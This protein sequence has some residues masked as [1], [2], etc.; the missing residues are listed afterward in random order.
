[1]SAPYRQVFRRAPGIWSLLLSYVV[2]SVVYSLGIQLYGPFL[3]SLVECEVPPVPGARFSGSAYCGDT[4]R[5]LAVAQ[6]QEGSLVS[7]KLAVHAV[8]G[9]FLG[10]FADR[11]GRRPVLLA[12]L[13]GY[14]VAF[15]LLFVVAAKR[16]L[17][18]YSLL[19]LVFFIEG[20]TNA[21]D[22]VYMSMI[23]DITSTADRATAFAAYFACSAGGQVAAQLLSVGILR[24]CLETYLAVWLALSVV[25]AADVL[26]AWFSVVETLS[27]PRHDSFHDGPCSSWGLHAAESAVPR[28]RDHR[29]NPSVPLAL[30]VLWDPFQ[31]VLSAQFLR[32]WLLSVLLT[33]LAAGLSSILAAF[34]IGVYG[35]RPGDLQ[36]YTWFSQLL[37]MGSLSCISPYA[38]RVGS[39]AAIVLVQVLLT[40]AA[41]F[42]QVFAPFSPAMLLGPGYVVDALAFANSASAALLSAQFGAE[43]QAKV[44]AVQHLCSNLGTSFSIALFSSPLLFK[45]GF[46]RSAAARPFVVAFALGLIGGAMKAHLAASQLGRQPRLRDTPGFRAETLGAKACPEAIELDEDG[47]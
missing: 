23:A 18:S 28:V 11:T 25:L 24:M 21:F 4:E 6:V 46:R 30:H 17:H 26:F 13:G 3:R 9:P 16:S 22:V 8:A 5:V 40:V 47:L 32:L 44:H 38:N 19:F 27:T 12:S 36:A 45:P 10:S 43:Q 29:C 20:A 33:S 34:S 39:P 1:M 7:M 42:V 41:T 31:L 37:R 14:A 35:W 2:V 15:L